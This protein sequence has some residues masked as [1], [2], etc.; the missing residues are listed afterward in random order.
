MPVEGPAWL[1]VFAEPMGDGIACVGGRVSWEAAA[2]SFINWMPRL[3]L[4]GALGLR[5]YCKNDHENKV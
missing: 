5:S 3:R 4:H 2:S 1:N